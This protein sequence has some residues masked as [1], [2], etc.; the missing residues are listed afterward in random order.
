VT[1]TCASGLSTEADA[2]RALDEVMREAGMVGAD[3]A[4][5]FLSGAH[6]ENAAKFVAGVQS[7]IGPRHLIGCSA[8]GVIGTRAEVEAGPA[9]ALWT[10]AMPGVEIE[11]FHLVAES[12]GGA[13]GEGEASPFR[14]RGLPACGD[15]ETLLLLPDPYT[16][17]VE[18]LMAQIGPGTRV[19]GGVASA[20]SAPG[21]N[22]LVHGQKVFS[23][24]A[25]GARLRGAEIRPVVSQ[26]CRPIGRR[27]VVTKAQE[28]L[29]VTLAGRP[30]FEQLQEVLGDLT[31]EDRSLARRGL[32]IGFALDEYKEQHG[33]GDFLIRSVFGVDPKSGAI[34]VSDR[35]RVGQTVQFQVRDG[36]SAR[37]D[38]ESLLR[39]VS[40]GDRAKGA[41]LF[42]CNGRGTHMYGAPDGDIGAVRS[43]LG[44][45]AAAGFFAAGEIGPVG[46]TNH[47]HGFT[48]SLALLF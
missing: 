37:D 14:F 35:F 43:V 3:L 26:G 25:V 45:V 20:G 23:V 24:G 1:V 39:R 17:P 15:G 47:L 13:G 12:A 32:Q 27:F 19:I 34:A 29:L 40:A 46:G 22:R 36:A 7:R 6:R 41:L 4:L 11:S 16:V 18:P 9:L 44:H 2:E 21:Q 38:L 10:A 30:A 42:S 8:Q 48:A 28:N 33:H 31:Q 5:L